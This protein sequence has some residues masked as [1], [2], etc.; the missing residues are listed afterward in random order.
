VPVISL[1]LDRLWGDRYS[2]PWVIVRTALKLIACA[3]AAWL[4][5][6]SV[7]R[8]LLPTSAT[9]KHTFGEAVNRA[10]DQ[11]VNVCRLRPVRLIIDSADGARSVSYRVDRSAERK[12]GDECV[13]KVKD[14]PAGRSAGQRV[15]ATALDATYIYLTEYPYFGLARTRL[16]DTIDVVMRRIELVAFN[17]EEDGDVKLCTETV[18]RLSAEDCAQSERVRYALNKDP[19]VGEAFGAVYWAALLLGFIQWATLSLFLLAFVDSAG[20]FARWL[21]L[22]SKLEGLMDPFDQ[23]QYEQTAKALEREDVVNILDKFGIATWRASTH[24]KGQS[25][26]QLQ[27]GMRTILRDYR[28]HLLDSASTKQE[29]LD[30]LGDSILKIAFFGTV[31]GIGLA[32]FEATKLDASDALSRLSTKADMYAGIGIG[33][34]ATMVGIVLSIVAGLMRSALS[35]RW[36]DTIE[37]GYRVVLD[38][39]EKNPFAAALDPPPLPSGKAKSMGALETALTLVG[40]LALAFV[41]YLVF[42]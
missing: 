1:I 29:G 22:R 38:F 28:D 39:Y 20:L 8:K 36:S 9:F 14:E 41:L 15:K 18:V 32:L 16:R 40:I 17:K 27:V 35:Q 11:E 30:L 26:A 4:I 7:E 33:F 13:G 12:L 2:T 24:M 6:W 31:L 37:R 21:F 42:R 5:H 23:V 10:L 34:G 19:D 25:P 3:S